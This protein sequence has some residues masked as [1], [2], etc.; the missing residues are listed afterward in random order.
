MSQPPFCSGYDRF[1]GG[2]I[3]GISCR[4]LV[5]EWICW[6]LTMLPSLCTIWALRIFFAS[7]V[8]ITLCVHIGLNSSEQASLKYYMSTV[9]IHN[10]S[11]SAALIAL[12]QAALAG[13]VA[14][15]RSVPMETHENTSVSLWEMT[16][17]SPCIR[18]TGCACVWD[19]SAINL[20]ASANIKHA[21]TGVTVNTN[22]YL[23]N[24]HR[25]ISIKLTFHPSIHLHITNLPGYINS[26]VC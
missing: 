1:R 24:A 12:Q 26:N 16:E 7:K 18:C 20:G 3:S 11:W 17:K 19:T 5:H 13:T 15:T 2:Y 22:E 21:A 9:N 4:D 25:S 23:I 10:I 8:W 6:I 14:R